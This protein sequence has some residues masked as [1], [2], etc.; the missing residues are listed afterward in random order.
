M[1]KGLKA[2]ITLL[3]KKTLQFGSLLLVFGI[4]LIYQNHILLS[5]LTI[6]AVAINVYFFVKDKREL[7]RASFYIR[8]KQKTNLWNTFVTLGGLSILGFVYYFYFKDLITKET[9]EAINKASGLYIPII[10]LSTSLGNYYNRFKTSIRSFET[11]I[12]IPGNR[13]SIINWELIRK[14][15]IIE[16]SFVIDFKDYDTFIFNFDERDT[17]D[18]VKIKYQ[19]EINS[20]KK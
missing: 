20:K 11:G 1:V 9:W 5:I 3:M 7:V 10:I 19:F 15:E 4:G 6:L 12:T 2:E 16:N 14:I 13:K 18:A 17:D 8:P